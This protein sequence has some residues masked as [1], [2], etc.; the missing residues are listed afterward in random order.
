MPPR[1]RAARPE[2]P[3]TQTGRLLRYFQ[4]RLPNGHSAQRLTSWRSGGSFGGDG[5]QREPPLHLDPAARNHP[6]PLPEQLVLPRTGARPPTLPG[7]HLR[8]WATAATTG[9]CLR[10]LAERAAAHPETAG[11]GISTP[12]HNRRG[13]ADRGAILAR[14]LGPTAPSSSSRTPASTRPAPARRQCTWG[15]RRPP[16][17]AYSLLSTG[18]TP[19]CATLIELMT[20]ASSYA[21]DGGASRRPWPPSRSPRTGRAAWS[22]P[23]RP[24]G[25]KH[26]GMPATLSPSRLADPPRPS[27]RDRSGRRFARGRH[28][29]PA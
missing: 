27:R 20:P 13:R 18:P 3:H 19:S 23:T 15:S 1:G 7:E 6:D 16:L 25:N 2:G 9:Y 17:P 21:A 8:Y 29:K 14:G 28:G 5:L 24:A 4:D 11:A 26:G 22:A 12:R 10:A